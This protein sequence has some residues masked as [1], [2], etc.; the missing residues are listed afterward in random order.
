MLIPSG[1]IGIY[2]T[3]ADAF[4]TELGKPCKVV[5]PK[6]QSPCPNC[7]INTMTRRS[8]NIYNGTGPT[9]FATG[10]ICP[11]CNGEGFKIEELFDT[12]NLRIYYDSKPHWINAGDSAQKAG[13]V[14][15]VICFLTDLPK[16]QRCE[17]II[18][19]TSDEGY[20]GWRYRRVGEMVPYGLQT[21]RYARGYWQRLD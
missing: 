11:Y 12:V 20:G 21:D 17:Y 9:P 16:L 14:I 19:N 2:Q 8:A 13:A 10:T 6:K 7:V 15:Q 3:G 1:V 18:V 4:I 5:Y